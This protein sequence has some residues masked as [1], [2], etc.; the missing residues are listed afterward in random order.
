MVNVGQNL[1]NPKINIFI[2]P[3]IN[4]LLGRQV[5]RWKEGELH[6]LMLGSSHCRQMSH[7]LT[8]GMKM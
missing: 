1:T 3:I 7:K 4:E 6:V 2:L 8:D 5:I